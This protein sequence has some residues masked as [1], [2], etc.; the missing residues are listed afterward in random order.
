MKAFYYQGKFYETEADLDLPI[1]NRAFSYG[2]GFF[3]TMRF[4]G[5]FIFNEETHINRVEQ[6]S[7]TLGNQISAKTIFDEISD[8]LKTKFH[9][10][11]LRLRCS[12]FRSGVAKYTPEADSDWQFLLSIENLDS[13]DFQLNAA[14]LKL[15]FYTEQAKAKGKLANI[16]SLSAQLYVQA[17]LFAKAEKLDDVLLLNTA[18]NVIEATAS[19]IFAI[20]SGY[21]FTPSLGEAPVGGTMR[22][23]L[24][25]KA[26]ELGLTASSGVLS[27]EALLAA[28]EI[29]LTNAIRGVSWVAQI[30]G[31]R[32]EQ[33]YA[34]KA[35]DILNQNLI[36]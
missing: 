7:K 18:G 8:F 33:K 35:I 19:N 31:K 2:D 27:K 6:S 1:V 21:L 25:Q 11:A 12:F 34:Q 17:S 32:F 20:K 26:S 9:S 28:D 3:E 23:L 22:A 4:T 13:T 5:E 24:L 15:G 16:K 30:E 14:G 29:W 10:Q 36:S